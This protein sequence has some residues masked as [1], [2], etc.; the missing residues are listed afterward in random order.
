MEKLFA[1]HSPHHQG[2]SF[3]RSAL[4]LLKLLRSAGSAISAQAALHSQLIQVEWEEEKNRLSQLLI[5]ALLGLICAMCLLLSLSFLAIALSW[6]TAYRL[7]VLVALPVIYSL[8]LFWVWRRINVLLALSSRTF[9]ATREEIAADL[10]L[11]KSR[12]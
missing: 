2:E 7:H 9:A 10:A 4:D 3:M 5:F 1:A 11:I 8:V 12:L 6:D